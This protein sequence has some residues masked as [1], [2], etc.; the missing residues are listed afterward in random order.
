VS[1]GTARLGKV[2]KGSG[3]VQE[4]DW[5]ERSMWGTDNLF[6]NAASDRNNFQNSGVDRRILSCQDTSWFS[7]ASDGMI[8][9]PRKHNEK[10]KKKVANSKFQAI[11]YIPERTPEP[12][13]LDM[14]EEQGWKLISSVQVCSTLF[15]FL[16]IMFEFCTSRDCRL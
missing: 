11:P 12:D 16:R 6:S 13:V 8:Y 5:A 1:A 14:L 7:N 9:V 3:E 15:V 4:Y 2:A 10:G